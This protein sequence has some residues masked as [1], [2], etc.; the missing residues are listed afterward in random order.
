MR[1]GKFNLLEI[2]EE[3][4]KITNKISLTQKKKKKKEKTLTLN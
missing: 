3:K 4:K 1:L 2:K